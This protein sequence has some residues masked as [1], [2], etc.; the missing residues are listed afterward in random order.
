MSSVYRVSV[1]IF[2]AWALRRARMYNFQFLHMKP[3][4]FCTCIIL[5]YI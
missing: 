3:Q 2:T 5:V 4:A 1:H